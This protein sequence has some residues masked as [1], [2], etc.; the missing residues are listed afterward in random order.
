[1]L[2]IVGLEGWDT[3]DSHD[4]NPV[5][6]GAVGRQQLVGKTIT[7]ALIDLGLRQ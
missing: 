1:M 4:S 3:A 6:A 5:A 2:D 7:H